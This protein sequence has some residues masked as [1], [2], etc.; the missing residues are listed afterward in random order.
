MIAVCG[1]AL[2]DL[3][4]HDGSLEPIPG[5]R[6][7]NTAVALGKLGASVSFVGAISSDR[8][9]DLLVRCL[10]DAGVDLRYV[11]RRTVPTPLAVVHA[12]D[13]GDHDF[14]FYLAQ[15]AYSDWTAA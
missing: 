5:G 10:D 6:P 15:T 14:T 8:F 11:M 12:D 13:D 4:T 9:G 7:F 2:I 3:V 1:E